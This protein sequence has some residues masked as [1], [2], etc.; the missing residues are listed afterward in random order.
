MIEREA[1]TLRELMIIRGQNRD[2]IEAANQN[3]GSALGWK[4]TN[5]VRT[6]HPAVIVFVPD[7]LNKALVP[8]HQRVPARLRATLHAG[9]TIFCGTDVVRGGKISVEQRP[10]LLSVENQA[11]VA[12]LRKGYIGLI[13]GVQ[14]GGFDS[15]IGPYIGTAGCTVRDR[16]G[17]VGLLTSRYVAGS[18][19]RLIYYPRPGQYSIGFCDRAIEHLFDH[20]HFGGI[21]DETN[22]FVRLDCAAVR[23]NASVA[24]LARPGLHELGELGDVLPIDIDSMDIIGTEVTSIGRTCGIQKGVIAAYAY[25]FIDDEGL[26]ICTDLLIVGADSSGEFSNVGDCGKLIVAQKGARP[27]ALSFGGWQARL[28]KG[29]EQENWAYAADLSKLLSYLD[30]EILRH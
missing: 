24:E 15:I 1:A 20:T 21:V 8:R 3:L 9:G 27:V 16:Q 17:R 18:P 28:R 2:K 6:N 7:K 13:G 25:E 19:G 22:C 5:G 12:E 11:V 14:L 26:S 23:L 30:I 10:P 29:Y 4:H